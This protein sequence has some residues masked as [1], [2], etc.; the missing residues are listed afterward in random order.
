MYNIAAPSDQTAQVAGLPMIQRQIAVQTNTVKRNARRRA[1]DPRLK[2]QDRQQAAR[3]YTNIRTSEMQKAAEDSGTPYNPNFA[4]L[5]LSDELRREQELFNKEMQ[6]QQGNISAPTVIQAPLHTL[7][8]Q[9]GLDAAYTSYAFNPTRY[10][11]SGYLGG[12]AAT[13]KAD[14]AL[15]IGMLAGTLGA[16]SPSIAPG[17][18]GGNLIGEAAGMEATAR[19]FDEGFNAISGK[20]I[21]EDVRSGLE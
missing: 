12:V 5:A 10:N 11:Q 7:G 19:L 15:G 2:P 17:T 1:V 9:P 20:D 13:G 8:T 16:V 18:T 21:G 6:E 3:M 4:E 14:R